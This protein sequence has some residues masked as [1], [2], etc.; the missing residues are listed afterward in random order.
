MRRRQ[1]LP[2]AGRLSVIDVVRV[3]RADRDGRSGQLRMLAGERGF[4]SVEVMVGEAAA[5]WS[6]PVARR[7]VRD[8]LAS[9]GWSSD[10]V[11]AAEGFADEV[12]LLAWLAADDATSDPYVVDEWPSMLDWWPPS[13]DVP[14]SGDR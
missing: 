11:A 12:S 5:A 3:L 1:T 9:P 14:L 6:G 13:R 2:P 10:A 8:R 7:R 4:P